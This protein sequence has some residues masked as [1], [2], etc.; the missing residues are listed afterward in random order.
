MSTP[1]DV[2]A[3]SV[4]WRWLRHLRG[5]GLVLLG[6]ADNSALP[7]VGS[8]DVFTIWLAAS[9]PR[10]WLYYAFMATVGA[11]AGGYIT[12]AIGRKGGKEA[13]ERKFNEEKAEKL[14]RRFARWGFAG[15]FV[16]A[17]MPPPFPLV[18][19]LLAAGAIQYPRKKSVA[20]SA[21]RC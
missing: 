15:V 17:M 1:S 2:F 10:L 14:L 5:P 18:P 13:I 20:P 6:I 19:V 8:M 3:L 4:V 12:Y 7:L 9:D 16:G 11:V 21:I